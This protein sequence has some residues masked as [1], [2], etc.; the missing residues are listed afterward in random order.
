MS[1]LGGAGAVAPLVADK[2]NEVIIYNLCTNFNPNKLNEGLIRFLSVVV[3]LIKKH[4]VYI[5]IYLDIFIVQNRSRP[6]KS[7]PLE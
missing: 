5:V 1:R 4:K 2:S 7:F 6:N 3:N